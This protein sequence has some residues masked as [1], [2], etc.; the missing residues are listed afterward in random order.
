MVKQ[1]TGCSSMLG[2][3]QEHGQV[4]FPV[5]SN[6]LELNNYSWHK[7]ANIIYLEAPGNVGFSYIDSYLLTETAIND[8]IVAQENFQ[9]KIGI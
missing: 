6:K 4:I 2:W 1:C 7:L 8:D 9:I 3:I 5:A